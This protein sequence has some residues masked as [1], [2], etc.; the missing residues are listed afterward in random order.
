MLRGLHPRPRSLLA[1][2]V[3]HLYADPAQYGL[4]RRINNYAAP[5]RRPALV[6]RVSSR[7]ERRGLQA[8]GGEAVSAWPLLRLPALPRP[9]LHQ[10]PGEPEVRRI[11]YYLSHLKSFCRWLVKDRRMPDNPLAHLEAGN[12]EMDRRHDRRELTADELR[13]LLEV[14]RASKRT[15]RGLAGRDRYHLYATACGTGFRASALASLTPE[16]FDVNGEPATV[17]LTHGGTRAAS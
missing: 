5:V 3:L 11:V 9:D 4:P 6:V 2:L 1:S 17:T 7:G 12:V 13:R 8:S 15:F 10:L 16:S 14:T